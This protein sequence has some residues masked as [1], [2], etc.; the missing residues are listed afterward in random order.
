MFEDF[1][2]LEEE[3]FNDL[4]EEVFDGLKEDVFRFFVKMS[5]TSGGVLSESSE[6][7]D[8]FMAS[9]FNDGLHFSGGLSQLASSL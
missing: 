1:K 8:K 7:V 3:F 4:E 2:D 5:K 9:F 6:L